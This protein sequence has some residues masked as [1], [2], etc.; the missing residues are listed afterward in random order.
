MNGIQILEN[1][2]EKGLRSLFPGSFKV[3]VGL[4]SCGRAAGAGTIYSMMDSELSGSGIRVGQTG[5]LGFCSREPL[6]EIF[7]P[8]GRSV[9]F[10]DVNMEKAEE[11]VASL[12]RGEMPVNGALG[13]RNFGGGEPLPDI[14]SLDSIPFYRK[15]KRLVLKNCGL[16]DPENLS[17]YV[18]TGGYFGLMKVLES[19]TPDEV[20]EEI[21]RSKLRG[22]G[23]AGFP[24]GLKWEFTRK[25]DGDLKY[26][27]CNAD[28]G[29]PGA[30]MDRTVL[31]G[32]PFS[33]IEG[34]TIGSY[35]MGARKGYIYV[36]AEYPLAVM[37]LEKAIR[38]ARKTGLLGKNILDTGHDFDI[39]I[40]EGAGAFVCGEETAL[41]A[42]IESERGMP[43]P[44]PPFP[45]NKGLWGKP[46]N[47]NNVETWANIPR[48]IEKGAGWFAGLGTERSGGTKVF[49]ITGNVK[50]TGLVEVPLGT[51]IRDLIFDIG[52]GVTGG[53]FKAVQTG[54]PSGGV[55]PEQY[56]DTPID[57]ENLAALGSI[58]GSGGMIVMN[59]T[60]CMVSMARFFIEFTQDESCGK[61]SPCRLGT[62]RL[63]EMLERLTRGEGQEGDL[64]K[65]EHLAKYVK[66]CALCGLGKTAPNPVLSTLKYFREEYEA[67]IAGRCLTGTCE[68][69]SRG[70][71]E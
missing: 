46:T 47:I 31:E 7:D 53:N 69:L 34:M 25:A 71:S 45:A 27:I 11:L 68:F 24:T 60:T 42:S 28:E 2:K 61:C 26:I 15:Q 21:K 56:L 44:R 37:R 12:K 29:D 13:S 62:K 52:G 38:I 55:I 22:R 30:Y 17:E 40:K 19:Y 39:E 58:M 51:P 32:D 8:E 65:L 66:E 1:L 67:H 18:A 10:G 48:I 64:E 5:C 59:D 57:Y 4:S 63:L 41:I 36:R 54:G 49:S 23:G 35:A 50:Y 9:V 3:I 70:V 33:V 43:R 16:I 6:V 20:I 14:P